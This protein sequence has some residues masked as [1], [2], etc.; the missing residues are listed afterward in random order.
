MVK[1]NPDQTKVMPLLDHLIELRKRLLYSCGAFFIAF[2]LCFHFAQDIFDFLARPLAIILLNETG[3]RFIYTDLTEVFFTQLKVAFFGA[4]CLSFPIFATQLWKFVAP[5]LYKH[6]KMAFLPFLMAAP[7][8]FI[9]GA[10][11]LYYILLPVAW[12]FFL[13]FQVKAGTG[14][15][16]IE[17][18]AKVGEYISLVMKL[19]F[20]FGLCF[21]LPVLLVLMA[22]VG[23]ISWQT[24][25][26]KRRYAIIIIFVVAA[27]VTPPDPISQIS[28]AIPIILLYEISIWCAYFI[29]KNR[30]KN[31]KNIV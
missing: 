26:K 9:I 24:L 2:F 11:V 3:R 31:D 21:Q 5:G 25:A 15:L 20:A 8:M 13:G 23:L 17:L 22:K 12:Q 19:I 30:I 16:P 6:E 4:A 1:E 18:E 14:T 7:I 29:Q 27:I 10:S 28:L